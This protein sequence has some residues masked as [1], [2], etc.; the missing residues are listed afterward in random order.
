MHAYRKARHYVNNTEAATIA[1]AEAE[2]FKG[3]DHDALRRAIEF[4]QGLGC[5][6]VDPR[7][8]REAYDRALDVFLHSGVISKRHAYETVVVPPPDEG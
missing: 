5:W 3:I 6:Q 1:K 2:F 7:I 4:Y 8:T